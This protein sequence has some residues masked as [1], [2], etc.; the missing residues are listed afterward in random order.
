[1]RWR[2]FPPRHLFLRAC[3]RFANSTKVIQPRA[4]SEDGDAGLTPHVRGAIK[5]LLLA[6][7]GAVAQLA[8]RLHGMEEVASS[9]LAGSTTSQHFPR[10]SV[11]RAGA[12]MCSSG[13]VL[14]ALSSCDRGIVGLTRSP[15]RRNRI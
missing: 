8:A 11:I 3:C 15:Q 12:V 5:T 9:N 1:M 4:P 6:S 13:T 2:C 14:G 10:W 7:G